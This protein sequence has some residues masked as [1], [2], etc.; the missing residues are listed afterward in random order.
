MWYTLFFSELC[1]ELLRRDWRQRHCAYTI[2]TSIL[3]DLYVYVN[4]YITALGICT[5]KALLELASLESDGFLFFFFFFSLVQGSPI[6]LMAIHGKFCSLALWF[7]RF[8]KTRGVWSAKNIYS[9]LT[10]NDFEIKPNFVLFR[11]C[12][13]QWSHNRKNV[14]EYSLSRPEIKLLIR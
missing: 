6:V 14:L 3:A 9:T 8:L 5:K 2:D 13:F 11:R 10:K 12:K 7:R 4:K 1:F